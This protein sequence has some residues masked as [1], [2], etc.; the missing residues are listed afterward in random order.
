MAEAAK[1]AHSNACPQA[2][3]LHIIPLSIQLFRVNCLKG[4][5]FGSPGV[6]RIK[7]VKSGK[8]QVT[9]AALSCLSPVGL[10]AANA[11][12]W[13][14][15]GSANSSIRV[16]ALAFPSCLPQGKSAQPGTEVVHHHL[17]T[18]TRKPALAQHL[19]EWSWWWLALNCAPHS[20]CFPCTG[21]VPH[22][23]SIALSSLLNHLTEYQLPN[24]RMCTDTQT[25]LQV[26]SCACSLQ[27]H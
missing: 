5:C 14:Q 26:R 11:T 24:P 2:T 12:E 23:L 8:W 7:R 16:T 10:I 27:W 15:I 1:P 25:A 19:E 18:I 21:A 6:S 9:S 3:L 20:I 22:P 17:C 13:N 4:N